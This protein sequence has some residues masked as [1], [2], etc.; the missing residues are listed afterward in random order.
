MGVTVQV[1]VAVL[2]GRDRLVRHRQSPV[3]DRK[4]AG[5]VT[6]SEVELARPREQR[7][8]VAVAVS[9]N[10]QQGCLQSAKLNQYELSHNVT[11]VNDL[12]DSMPVQ[13]LDRPPYLREVIVRIRDDS[14]PTH[15]NR[16]RSGSNRRSRTG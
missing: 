5:A 10:A 15:C 2:R 13:T 8:S 4:E 14:Y 16:S 9:E 1:E 12:L 6:P 11:A 7:A 3:P